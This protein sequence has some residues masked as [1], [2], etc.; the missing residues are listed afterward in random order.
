MLYIKAPTVITNLPT[1]YIVQWSLEK[2]AE[3]LDNYVFTI[4]T[5]TDPSTG[6][7]VDGSVQNQL[8]Y[9]H[10]VR[11][12]DLSRIYYY[13][14]Q[15]QNTS[16]GEIATTPTFYLEA[17]PSGVALSM[18]DKE[19][20]FLST[21]IAHPGFYLIRKKTGRTCPRCFD[22]L[23]RRDGDPL[24]PVCY[25]TGYLGGYYTPVKIYFQFVEPS[26][27]SQPGMTVFGQLE[28]NQVIVWMSNFP[29]A[30]ANDALVDAITGIAYLV[31]AVRGTTFGGALIRQILTLQQIEPPAGIYNFPLPIISTSTAVATATSTL[32]PRGL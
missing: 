18:I 10:N 9:L 23:K 17:A 21:I 3:N 12:Y 15:V 19:R 24:C 29:I 11:N 2:T 1:G 27:I 32:P 26:R 28:A 4:L 6:F 16:T 7:A 22:Q 5:S 25:G 20:R 8:Y 31:S 13:Q 30:T 14:I